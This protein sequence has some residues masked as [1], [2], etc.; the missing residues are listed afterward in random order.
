MKSEQL[1]EKWYTFRRIYCK[2][3]FIDMWA[4]DCINDPNED[5]KHNLQLNSSTTYYRLNGKGL[6]IYKGDLKNMSKMIC[7]DYT[8]HFT[9]NEIWEF[10]QPK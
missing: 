5:T 10:V 7:G 2:E 6:W 8:I 3:G 9:A 4:G 1:Q